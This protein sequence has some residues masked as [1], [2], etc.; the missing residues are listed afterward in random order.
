MNLKELFE[1]YILE[2]QYITGLSACTINNDRR[3]FDAF[4]K[5]GQTDILTRAPG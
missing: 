1:R 2:K 4:Y 3:S 5:H